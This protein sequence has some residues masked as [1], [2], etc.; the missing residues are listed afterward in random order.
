MS[1]S[2]IEQTLASCEFFK[3]LEKEDIEK[4]ATLCRVNSFQAGEY[5]FRQ[6]DFGEYICIVA[7]GCV[8]LEREM[9][10]GTRKGNVLIDVLGNGRIFGCWSSLLDKPHILMASACCQKSTKVVFIR[11]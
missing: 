4:I 6:S 2:E 10:L 5:V 9:N 8:L 11:G 7:E 3:G 1:R